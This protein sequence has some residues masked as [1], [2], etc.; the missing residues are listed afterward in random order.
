[1]RLER[2]HMKPLRTIRTGS[3]GM[4]QRQEIMSQTKTGF[5]HRE[6]ALARPAIR[7]TVAPQKNLPGLLKRGS[8]WT[9]DVAV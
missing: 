4:P 1:M 2:D 6:T 7:Q 3:P 8:L 5:T 9:I